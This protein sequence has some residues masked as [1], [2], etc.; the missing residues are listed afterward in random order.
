MYVIPPLARCSHVSDNY[1]IG[2]K[3]NVNK[4]DSTL[5]VET[6]ADGA[7]IHF[8]I[9]WILSVRCLAHRLELAVKGCFKGTFMDNVTEML[10]LIY[11][12][13]KGSAERKKEVAEL[14]AEIMEEH[15]HKPGKA[16]GTRWVD[17]KLRSLTKLIT[18]W[19]LIMIHLQNYIKDESNKAEDR[20]K[21]QGILKKVVE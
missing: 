1:P 3:Q 16:N 4:H 20:A 12:F 8:Y 13:Y 17:H 5:L 10:T 18:N 11:Y 2:A 6:F 21:G 9:Y 7:M 14:V 15:F 19:K